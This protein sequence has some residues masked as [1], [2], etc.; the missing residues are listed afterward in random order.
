MQKL[1][2]MYF[3]FGTVWSG[4]SSPVPSSCHIWSRHGW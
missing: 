1:H 2:W 4:W 3:S